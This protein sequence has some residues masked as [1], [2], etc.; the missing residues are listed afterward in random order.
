MTNWV[1]QQHSYTW[2]NENAFLNY[3]RTKLPV[4]AGG[5]G[6][7]TSVF[8]RTGTVVA[9]SGDYTFAQIGSTPTTLLGYGITDSITTTAPI[10]GG[11]VL[12]SG[13]TL[14]W[15]FTHANTWT[16]QQTFSTAN[17]I[18]STGNGIDWQA[19]GTG[20]G[21]V[22]TDLDQG[23]DGLSSPT[24]RSDGG[25][26][27][28][29]LFRIIPRGTGYVGSLISGMQI[30]ST[31]PVADSNNYSYLDIRT[32]N[33]SHQIGSYKLGTGTVRDI[34][35]AAGNT[36]QIFVS[37]QYTSVG[38]GRTTT[39]G[40]FFQITA[41][42]AGSASLNLQNGVA[43]TSPVNGDL[44]FDGTHLQ[45]RNTNTYQLDQQNNGQAAIVAATGAIANTDTLV[46]Q[47]PAYPA[48]RFVAGTVVRVT[49]VGTS[50]GGSTP[51]AP[52]FRLHIG[53]A[54]TVA[55][56]I[57]QTITLATAATSGTNIPFTGVFEFTVLTTG[58]SATSG[59][60]MQIIDP[61]ATG[62]G[63]TASQFVLGVQTNT[64]NTTTASLILT[65]SFQ[66]GATN[67]S[68]NFSQ[69]FIEIVNK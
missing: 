14:A 50:T 25:T 6:T 34:L 28:G 45:F 27:S 24:F 63:T 35:I 4:I 2:Y 19:S 23:A 65:F 29:V 39:T 51:G 11:G 15:D 17:V 57:V 55:D 36:N 26:N 59:S 16:G 69:A 9:T 54:G 62:I 67:V 5:G 20:R 52:I 68:A 60:S 58:A 32:T 66:S 61:G 37:G 18:I 31:D 30:Y 40:A 47:T 43:P 12:N 3:L 44:W 8:G 13:L 53:T 41:S 1:I 56:T 42:V 38:I 21:V 48:S 22:L 10:T 46:V 33:S 7:I 49:V 64:F